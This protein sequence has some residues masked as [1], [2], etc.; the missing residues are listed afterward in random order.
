MIVIAMAMLGRVRTRQDQN[1][2][3]QAI[4]HSVNLPEVA[5]SATLWKWSHPSNFRTDIEPAI[6]MKNGVS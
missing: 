1:Q 6:P 3:Q 5:N 2:K 4:Q